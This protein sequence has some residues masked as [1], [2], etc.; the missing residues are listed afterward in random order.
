VSAPVRVGALLGHADDARFAGRRLVPV[1]VAWDE[2]GRRR[3]R[4]AAA[5]GTDVVVDLAHAAYLADGAVLHDDGT[6]ILVVARTP[7]PALV[8]RLDPTAPPARLVAQALA[9]GHAFGNQHVP[10]DVADGEAR[11]PLTTSEAVARA[12]VEALALEGATV[13]LA[14]VALGRTRPLPVGHAHGHAA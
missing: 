8:V 13:E 11:I 5:D 6:R 10:I 1:P 12:T 7:E 9:L 2:A 14:E 4:R 3:L